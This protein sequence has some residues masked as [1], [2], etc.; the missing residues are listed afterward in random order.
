MVD[1]EMGYADD[2][3]VAGGVVSREKGTA[4]AMIAD[5]LVDSSLRMVSSSP[6]G[7]R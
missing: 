2:G 3:G 4:M 7:K 5:S 6:M 1:N